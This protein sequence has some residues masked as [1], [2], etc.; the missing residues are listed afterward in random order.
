M[1]AGTNWDTAGSGSTGLLKYMQS[2][3]FGDGFRDY[4]SGGTWRADDYGPQALMYEHGRHFAAAA[5]EI[6]QIKTGRTVS[7]AAAD[8]L[9]TLVFTEQFILA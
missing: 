9:N 6:L 4:R 7:R 5:P 1:T 8:R 2:R 3:A